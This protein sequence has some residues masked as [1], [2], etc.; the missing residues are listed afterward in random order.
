MLMLPTISAVEFNTAIES[1]NF[2]I[3]ERIQNINNDE[4]EEKTRNNRLGE[5]MIEII[6]SFLNVSK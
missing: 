2:Q 5:N 6:V 1:N 3:L 4:I